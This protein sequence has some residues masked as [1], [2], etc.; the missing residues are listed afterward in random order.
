[1]SAFHL[2]LPR[3]IAAAFVMLALLVSLLPL[4]NTASAA[5]YSSLEQ[6]AAVVA[7][8]M[9]QWDTESFSV[10]FSYKSSKKLGTQEILEM[11]QNAVFAHNGVP[12]QGDYLAT[13]GVNSLGFGAVQDDFDGTTH[14]ITIDMA[15]SLEVMSTKAEEKALE[16]KIQQVLSS[17]SLNGKSDYDKIYAIYDYIC[18]NVTYDTATADKYGIWPDLSIDH[19]RQAY[20][21]YGALINGTAVCQGYTLLLYRMLLAAGIDNRIMVGGIHS[22]NIVRLGDNYYYLDATW[23][24]GL[25]EYMWF[26]RGSSFLGGDYHTPKSEYCTPEFKAKYPIPLLDYG[27]SWPS[28]DVLGSGSCGENATWTLSGDG[29]MT[30]RGTGALYDD[31]ALTCFQDLH[32]YV[33]KVI[34]ESGITAIGDRAFQWCSGLEEIQIPDTVTTIGSSAFN[35]CISLKSITLPDSV[36]SIGESC[37]MSCHCLKTVK[38]SSKLTEIPTY[39]F[40]LCLSL[41]GLTIPASVKKI[42]YAAFANAFSTDG[43]ASV[44]IPSTVTEVGTDTFIWS[45]VGSVTYNASTEKLPDYAFYWC[46]NLKSVTIGDSV[47]EIGEEAFAKSW[48]LGS[49]KLPKNLRKANYRS[50]AECYNLTS[51]TIPGTLQNIAHSM[52]MDCEYLTSVTIADGVKTIEQ[53]AFSGCKRLES[54]TIPASVTKM[55]T[56]VFADSSNLKTL[57]FL[58]NAPQMDSIAGLDSFHGFYGTLYYPKG[59][60]TWQSI[61]SDPNHSLITFTNPHADGT[62]HTPGPWQTTKNQHHQVCTGCG[63][64]IGDAPHAWLNNACSICG[65][66]QG[67]SSGGNTGDNSS[68]NAEV[69]TTPS[70]EPGDTGDNSGGS[71]EVPTTPSTEPTVPEIIPHEHEFNILDFQPTGHWYRCAVEGCAE[72]TEE[73][74]HDFSELPCGSVCAECG[75]DQDSHTYNAFLAEANHHAPMCICGAVKPG[76]E[77]AHEWDTGVPQG[78]GKALYTCTV[79]GYDKVDTSGNIPPEDNRQILLILGI[80]CGVL[81]LFCGGVTAFVLLKKH[82]C[83][84]KN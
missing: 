39:A 3:R 31:C 69:P 2:S 1:M 76:E 49:V 46:P 71:T 21:A 24:A 20:T 22:W 32:I 54:I 9:A 65:Y 23:D 74:P 67:S 72:H 37:F 4:A 55:G 19:V 50:F 41:T 15:G 81:L 66:R 18:K 6:A 10:S 77:T 58:G 28:G 61:I 33:K 48:H 57:Q 52:F 56:A 73:A 16:Q 26:L 82:S 63:D 27:E 78:D 59:N 25:T 79:C 44:T 35:S 62:L 80:A 17:L 30:I 43:S 36:T 8:K 34:I 11:F 42:G 51:I 38:L 75:Y 60:S 12:N 40:N 7:E 70:T 5:N 64:I 29:T 68:G 13:Q 45:F 14:Y 84:P 53:M 47:T 83:K